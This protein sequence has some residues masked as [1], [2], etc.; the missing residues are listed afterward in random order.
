MSRPN[1][2]SVTEVATPFTHNHVVSHCAE[3]ANP[4]KKPKKIGMPHI[5]SRRNGSTT[6]W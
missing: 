1:W 2:G 4:A 6:S 5:A 3:A